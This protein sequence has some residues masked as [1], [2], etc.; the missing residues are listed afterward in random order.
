MN[1]QNYK[2]IPKIN[3]KNRIKVDIK[4]L[5]HY[6]CFSIAIPFYDCFISQLKDGFY[7]ISTIFHLCV[8]QYQK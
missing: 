4:I 6:F 8:N 3:Q 5:E 7:K 1:D 2:E